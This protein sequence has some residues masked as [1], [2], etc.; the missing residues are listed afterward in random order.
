ML[1]E[2][3]RHF[4]VVFLLQ[5]SDGEAMRRLLRRAQLEGRADDTPEAI[6]RRLD[7][8]HEETE[9]L[10]EYYRTR[11][12]LVTVPGERSEGEVFDELQG[13]LERLATVGPR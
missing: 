7:L 8:Y 11:G 3:A 9:P 4:T 1:N 2:I 5:L 12:H 10:V 6:Q 13:V